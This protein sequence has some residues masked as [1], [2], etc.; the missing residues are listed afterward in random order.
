ME[1]RQKITKKRADPII[2]SQ[3]SATLLS[4]NTLQDDHGVHHSQQVQPLNSDEDD[5]GESGITDTLSLDQKRIIFEGLG[6]VQE[7][8]REIGVTSGVNVEIIE[9]LRLCRLKLE[10]TSPP[11]SGNDWNT[12]ASLFAQSPETELARLEPGQRPKGMCTSLSSVN[13]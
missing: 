11:R 2:S 6:R 1:I 3:P 12:Y 4:P 13:A 5:R 9:H 10:G 8:I 7:L